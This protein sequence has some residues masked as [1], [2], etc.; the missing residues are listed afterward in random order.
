MDFRKS[1]PGADASAY[2]LLE[3]A[4]RN[5]ER[6][7]VVLREL[8][9]GFPESRALSGEL[10]DIEHEGDRITHALLLQLQKRPRNNGISSDDGHALASALDDIVDFAEQTGDMMG[11]YR[12][13]AP[14]EQAV[15]M[16]DVL[17]A[18][19][20]QVAAALGALR[21]GRDFGSALIEINRLE[22]E[23]DRLHREALASLFSGGIDPMV[24]IRWKD[25]F[26]W[27]EASIDSCERVA[28]HLEGIAIKQGRS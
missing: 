1:G 26:T 24:V 4:G 6:S 22:N 13:E 19:S 28:H 27:L 3:E 14:M 18:C 8:V 9:A 16:C 12:I 5:A 17:V 25:I 10:T 2:E 11:I 20:A 21:A 7:A 23:G 15:L